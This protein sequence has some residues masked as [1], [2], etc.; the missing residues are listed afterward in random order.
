MTKERGK[1]LIIGHA[2]LGGYSLEQHWGYVE[3]AEANVSDPKGKPYNGKSLKTLLG[4]RNSDIV[5]IQKHSFLSGDSSSYYPYANKLVA[6]V[7]A[8]Q[9]Q[10]VSLSIKPRLIVR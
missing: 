6:Y 3:K 1:T 2:E 9:P 8:L 7:K 10:S 5:T 4:Q